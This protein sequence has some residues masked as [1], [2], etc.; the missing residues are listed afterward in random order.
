MEVACDQCGMVG[1]Q[2]QMSSHLKCAAKHKLELSVVRKEKDLRIAQL[3]SE[4]RILQG[5]LR[6]YRLEDRGD[7]EQAV[8]E[9]K[10]DWAEGGSRTWLVEAQ[11]YGAYKLDAE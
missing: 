8:E 5:E 2:T 10:K 3:E 9:E 7:R 11:R 6:R 4:I 1:R